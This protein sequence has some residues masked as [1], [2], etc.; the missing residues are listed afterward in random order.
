MTR[1]DP[2]VPFLRS[3]LLDI[4]PFL[5]V[6]TLILMTVIP[7]IMPSITRMGALWPLIGIAYWTLTRPRN[8][9]AP[10]VFFLGVL[11]DIVSF[12]PL[13]AHG[14]IFVMMQIIL[15]R[16]RRFLLGQGFWMLWT[17]YGV[18]GLS[19][20][21]GLYILLSPV[22]PSAVT[23]SQGLVAVA[24]SWACVPL[25]VAILSQL[26]TIMDLFDEPIV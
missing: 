25:V 19:V 16:Q 24:M 4:L 8:L 6:L 23:F 26:N 5:S 12:V 10:T 14:F 22:Q 15:K 11:M 18:L 17:A 3:V 21:T 7:D 9:R 20:Y 13:G 2:T 1:E